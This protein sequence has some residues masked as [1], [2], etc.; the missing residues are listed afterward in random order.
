MSTAKPRVTTKLN[1]YL[2]EKQIPLKF[3]SDVTGIR[4]ATLWDIAN[5]TRKSVNMTHIFQIMEALNIRDMNLI[6][7]KVS[8]Y[9]DAS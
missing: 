8:K 9:D 2:E 5:M 1:E 7:D 4:Y 3:V 6:F